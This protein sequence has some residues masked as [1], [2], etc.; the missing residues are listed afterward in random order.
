MATRQKRRNHT[1]CQTKKL[2]LSLVR[3][4]LVI[5]EPGEQRDDDAKYPGRADGRRQRQRLLGGRLG[6]F[7]DQSS[8]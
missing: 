6:C 8:R 3:C 2:I 7:E 4:S 1:Y 5:A